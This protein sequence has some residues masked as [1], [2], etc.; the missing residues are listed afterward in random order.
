MAEAAALE[1]RVAELEAGLEAVR[2]ALK[3]QTLRQSLEYTFDPRGGEPRFVDENGVTLDY[4]GAVQILGAATTLDVAQQRVIV[5]TAAGGGGSAAK[6]HA[7]PAIELSD[8]AT[9]PL[10]GMS[11]TVDV[12]DS[13][14][15]T[16]LVWFSYAAYFRVVANTTQQWDYAVDGAAVFPPNSLLTAGPSTVLSVGTEHYLMHT[17][18]ANAT[19]G[20]SPY[21]PQT[22]GGIT[23]TGSIALSYPNTTW[24]PLAGTPIMLRVPSGVHTLD[25]LWTGSAAGHHTDVHAVACAALPLG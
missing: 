16:G 14:D 21:N 12:T 13:G 1:A 19:S 9:A 23:C 25:M 17:G 4:A 3:P 8:T 7:S 15:G 18:Q 5:S 20:L 2:A 22:T 24:G 6:L 10:P 11:L